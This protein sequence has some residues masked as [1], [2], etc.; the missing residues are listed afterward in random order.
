[1]IVERRARRAGGLI[2]DQ[3][4]VMEQG[5]LSWKARRAEERNR[6]HAAAGLCYYHPVANNQQRRSLWN[7]WKKPVGR[8]QSRGTSP[9][10]ASLELQ[11]HQREGADSRAAPAGRGG[12]A[13]REHILSNAARQPGRS[14]PRHPLHTLATTAII[15]R[16]A[17]RRALVRHRRASFRDSIVSASSI[18]LRQD[19]DI[20]ICKP[21][22]LWRRDLRFCTPNAGRPRNG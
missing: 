17:P 18:V 19:Y 22:P 12:L 15:K 11:S 2:S 21:P 9:I 10:S 7:T 1:V 20:G 16:K 5:R 13:G 14:W 8:R 3:R 6:F 4:L